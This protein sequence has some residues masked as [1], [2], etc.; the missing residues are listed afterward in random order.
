MIVVAK[1]VKI[2]IIVVIENVVIHIVIVIYIIH[3][4]TI[5]I[6][7]P[8]IITRISLHILPQIILILTIPEY[9][10]RS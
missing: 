9:S 7:A 4:V 8:I 6:N 10:H 5:A 1:I 3:T 2:V